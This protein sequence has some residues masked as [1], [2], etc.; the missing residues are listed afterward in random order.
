MSAAS[1]V[2]SEWGEWDEWGEWGEGAPAL[3]H[4]RSRAWNRL[5]QRL[6]A[7]DEG[8]HD[9]GLVCAQPVRIEVCDEVLQG[10]AAEQDRAKARL[11][12][13][14]TNAIVAAC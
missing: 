12:G 3:A 13:E 2:S 9:L 7:K 1:L 10:H 8:A 6:A 4:A 11:R 14:G 5:A